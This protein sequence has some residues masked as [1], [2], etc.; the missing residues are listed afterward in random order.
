MM[1]LR[2]S[3]A[4][5][6]AYV[7]ALLGLPVSL[8]D[9]QPPGQIA[10]IITTTTDTLQTGIS[11]KLAIVIQ[12][13]SML[14]SALIVAYAHSW[15]LSLVTSSGLLLITICYCVTVPFLVRN[16]QQVEDANI[17]ASAVAS[18]VFSSIR[19]VAACGAE[20]KMV[21]RYREWVEEANRRG[22]RLSGIIGIQ[23]ATSELCSRSYYS[24]NTDN[25]VQSI[26]VSIRR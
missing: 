25:L 5:R 9:T 19:M 8:L 1:S 18:E 12:T 7:K 13:L 15:K 16:M 17:R 21:E 6:L 24:S 10:A 2:I 22:L 4:L 3:S 14:V 26:L 20:L 23:Q 11:E